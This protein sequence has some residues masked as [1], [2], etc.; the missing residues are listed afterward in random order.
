MEDDAASAS[1]RPGLARE[2][3]GV[4]LDARRLG[5][6]LRRHAERVPYARHG[7]L[8]RDLAERAEEQ[9]A[10]IARELRALDGNADPADPTAPHDGRNHWE[11]LS[12]DLGDLESLKRRYVEL[13]LRWDVDFPAVAAKLRSLGRAASAM[14]ST[15][16]DLLARSDPH[17][18]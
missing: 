4:F 18:A 8:L 10:T 2:L 13:A 15:V 17:A 1:L 7:T 3:R 6:Q 14:G 5:T 12:I 11:R 9:V 16:R